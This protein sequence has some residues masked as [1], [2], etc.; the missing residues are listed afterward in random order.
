MAGE[1]HIVAVGLNHRTAPVE[2]RERLAFDE[3]NVRVQL[4]RLRSDGVCEEALLVSTCNRV[5]LYA[6]SAADPADRLRA[7]L[8]G[9]TQGKPVDTYLAWWRDREAVSHLFQVAGSLDSM[10]LGEPQI[11]GQVKDAMRVAEEQGS[12]GRTLGPLAR[13]S[14]SVAKRIRTETAIGRSRVGIGN[15]GVDLA[16][17]LFGDLK[18]K[19][20]LLVGVGE[21]GRQVAQAMLNEGVKTL[22]VVNRTVERARELAGE[23]GPVAVA[24][25]WDELE[26]HLRAADIAI[27]AVGGTDAVLTKELVLRAMRRRW[28]PLFLVDLGVPRNIDPA[29][30]TL[31]EAYLFN[32]DD[33]QRVLNEGA[34]AREAASTDA[35]RIVTEEVDRFLISLKEVEVGPAIGKMTKHAELLRAAE[36]DRSRRLVDSLDASQR[37]DLDALTKS[38]VK[39]VLDGAVRSVREAARDLRRS[40]DR[41]GPR[42]VARRAAA[43][44]RRSVCA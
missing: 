26:V 12:L 31:D 44:P 25:S 35:Q 29:V 36:I 22:V 17:G 34:A 20:A 33:L 2:V 27:T 9:F 11:L 18:G 14:L 41:R 39:K 21:M 16:R 42:R 13:K 23:L 3:A 4:D 30:A 19:N 37:S 38:L 15:A 1:A 8:S 5:E 28:D 7:W 6:V 32:V 43:E 24:A 10:I 40:G